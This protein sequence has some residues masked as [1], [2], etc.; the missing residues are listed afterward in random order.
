M[1]AAGALHGGEMHELSAVASKKSS[2]TVLT[3]STE[4]GRDQKLKIRI[5]ITLCLQ[6][7]YYSCR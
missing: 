4:L 5:N 1:R 7:F 2:T 3:V 6:E